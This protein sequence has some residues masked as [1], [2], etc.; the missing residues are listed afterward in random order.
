MLWSDLTPLEQAEWSILAAG[1]LVVCATMIGLSLR[2]GWAR[3][4]HLGAPRQHDI[5]PADLGLAICA[6]WILPSLF[7]TLLATLGPASA[8]QSASQ[9]AVQIVAG[10]TQTLLGLG[11]S[12]CNIAILLALG[13][14]CFRGGLRGWGLTLTSFPMQIV[15]SVAVYIAVWP[16][17][18]VMLHG[19][20]FLLTEFG[21]QLESHATIT[22]LLDET[23]PA[24]AVYSAIASAVILAPVAEELLFRGL[25]LPAISR[26]SGSQWMGIIA[27][28]FMFGL[29]HMPLYQN[30]ASLML[31]GVVLGYVYVKSGS[32]TLVILVHA[33]FNAKTISWLLIGIT[34]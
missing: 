14:R 26:W 20:R 11:G 22:T 28:G 6:F 15:R 2:G 33:V 12:L 16:A 25:L 7:Y 18:V 19:M 13:H 27:S 3:A 31:F 23:T 29:I 17:C 9:P 10:P 34:P 5:Q 24:W 21:V 32:L 4:L 8:S 1:S 30:V